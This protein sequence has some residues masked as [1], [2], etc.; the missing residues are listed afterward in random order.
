MPLTP[1]TGP[2]GKPERT[3]LL[4]R[5]LFGCTNADLAHFEGQSLAQVVDALLTFTNDTTPPI[6][7]YWELNGG[8]PDPDAIDPAVPFGSTWVGVPLPAEPAP[9]PTVQ[10]IISWGAWRTGLQVQ[11]QRTL[12]EKLALCW[13]NTMPVQAVAAPVPQFLYQYE[14]LLRTHAMGNYRTLVREAGLSG[15]MLIYLNGTFNNVLQPD[16]N[17]ARELMELFTLGVGSGYTEA[18]VQQAARVMT[19]W[20]VQIDSGGVPV[21]PNTQYIPFLHDTGNKQF[22][23][24]FNNAVINGQAGPGGGLNEFNALLDLIFGKDECS[25]HVCRE[26]Y[27]FFVTGEIDAATEQDVI[28]PLA[29]LFRDTINAPDQIRQVMT[30]LLTSEHFFSA[31]VRACRIKSPADLVLGAIRQFGIPFP[32]PAQFEARYRIWA[33]V[34]GLTQFAGQEL[35]NPPNVAGWPAYH[36]A[37]MYDNMWVDGATFPNR[38]NAMLALVYVGFSTGNDIYQPASQNL[39]FKADLLALVA[40]FSNPYDPNALVEDATQLLFG[41]PVSAEVKQQLKTNYLL[42][43]QQFD[44]YWTDAYEIYVNDPNSPDPFAQ[45]V[46]TLLL[47]L[48]LDMVQAAENHLH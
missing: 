36:Q 3:H 5:A 17:Y 41:V 32:T 31:E 45:L 21:V 43:G 25:L 10:R 11:Q 29:Q 2:F 14:Q 19:G 24:F 46:P 28:V 7:A 48:F 40:Q 35:A 33:E 13:Y 16:E 8:V 44:H 12:R 27:R 9:N 26:I 23:A 34:Y 20:I 15:A 1:Y 47:L 6:K 39:S 37:P 22:S 4:R 38:N 30:A 42:L 18:D